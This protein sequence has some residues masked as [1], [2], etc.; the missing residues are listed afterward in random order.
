MQPTAMG[1]ETPKPNA[2]AQRAAVPHELHVTANGVRLADDTHGAYATLLNKK[3]QQKCVAIC[4]CTA[5]T[6]LM[7]RSEL[8]TF[9]NVV[10][11]VGVS[12]LGYLS[13]LAQKTVRFDSELSTFRQSVHFRTIVHF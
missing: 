13:T 10:K 1:M 7:H 3:Q 11:S 8:K 4:G 6:G 2:D 9:Q 12:F 5:K